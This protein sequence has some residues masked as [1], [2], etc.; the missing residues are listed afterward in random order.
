MSAPNLYIAGA[1]GFGREVAAYARECLA[2]GRLPGR[3]GGFLD[4]TGADP[5]AF[6]C[7][8]PVA[9]TILD[10]APNPG[11]MVVIAVGEPDGRAQVARRLAARGTRFA[12]L[13]H[14]LAYVA[15]DASVAEG[16]IIAPFATVAPHA[17]LG[18]HVLV[19]THAGIGHDARLGAAC[20][21]SPHAVINGW[22]EADEEVFVGSGAVVTSRLRLGRRSQVAAGAVVYADVPPEATAQGDPARARHL[23]R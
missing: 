13:V 7:D 16:C 22:V 6:G 15:A 5:A 23:P 20:V 18:P 19:N 2:A 1:G 11:D 12:T 8:V 21:V 9:G 17:V 4:D 3:L 10:F 14:P